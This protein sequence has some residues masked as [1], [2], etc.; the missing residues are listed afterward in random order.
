[1]ESTFVFQFCAQMY[2]TCAPGP[3]TSPLTKAS[4]ATKEASNMACVDAGI[5]LQGYYLMCE[6]AGL[7]KPSVVLD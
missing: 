5:V 7:P 4:H 1:M 2:F 3:T 6:A